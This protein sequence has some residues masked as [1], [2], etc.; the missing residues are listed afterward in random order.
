MKNQQWKLNKKNESIGTKTMG[1][2][3]GQNVPL[4]NFVIDEKCSYTI[5]WRDQKTW[6]L[7]SPQTLVCNVNLE[8]RAIFPAYDA[9]F[10]T[11]T[12][13]PDSNNTFDLKFVYEDILSFGACCFQDWFTNKVQQRIYSQGYYENSSSDECSVLLRQKYKDITSTWLIDDAQIES[14][15]THIDIHLNKTVLESK[16]VFKDYQYFWQFDKV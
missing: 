3:L 16:I 15:S 12:F 7:I 14:I 6:N 4:Q 2:Y 8:R 9:M 1:L 11:P 5:E 10:N 13:T